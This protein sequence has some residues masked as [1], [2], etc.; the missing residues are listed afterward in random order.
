MI[1][2]LTGGIACGKSTVSQM[3]VECGAAL[4]DADLVAREVV[5][6]DERGWHKVVE[7]FGEEILLPD[8]HLNRKKLGEIIFADPQAR[9]DLQS[10]L[11]PLIRER[12]TGQ[13]QE[14]KK[15]DP[16]RLVV[17]DVPLLFESRQQNKYEKTVV[18]YVDRDTQLNRLMKRDGLNEDQAEARLQS[19]MPIEQKKELA[20]Y[21]IDNRGTVESTKKQVE[22]L[23]EQLHRD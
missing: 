1:I 13:I 7:R 10:I 9:E 20:D 6:P 15:Q 5:K 8:R 4:V 18:V 22:A 3:L 14:L 21:V 19:Q 2:G 17:V 16:K 23:W 11:H 12:M